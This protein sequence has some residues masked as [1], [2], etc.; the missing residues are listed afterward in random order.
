MGAVQRRGCLQLAERLEPDGRIA[1]RAGLLQELAEK[2]PAEAVASQ[3]LLEQE[4]AHPR[5]VW[6]LFSEREAAGEDAVTLDYPD[7]L[8]RA[9]PPTA[10][11][12]CDGRAYVG[13]EA[14]IH[15]VL[16]RVD[17]T[18][19]S[20]DR[21]EVAG[22]QLS[23]DRGLGIHAGVIVSPSTDLCKMLLCT[24]SY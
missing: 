10:P 22:A 1:G 11:R 3:F 18:V 9:R 20:H 23:S 21:A 2:P 12:A 19:V 16:T 15:A 13:L 14:R 6:A 5:Q 7:S 4:P 24:D 8:P 17:L